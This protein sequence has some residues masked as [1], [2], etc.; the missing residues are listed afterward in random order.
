M[1]GMVL[2]I[3][4]PLAWYAYERWLH[5]HPLAL[6]GQPRDFLKMIPLW[7]LRFLAIPMLFGIFIWFIGGAPGRAFFMYAIIWAPLPI[8]ASPFLALIIWRQRD[9]NHFARL[10]LST[11]PLV[12][13]GAAPTKAVHDTHVP[14][15]PTYSSDHLGG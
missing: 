7:G 6:P 9:Q 5:R 3:L 15:D 8:Y 2:F 13:Q 10:H 1:F 4:S 14:S 12:I 11:E